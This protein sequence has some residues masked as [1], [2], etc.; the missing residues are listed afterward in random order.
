MSVFQANIDIKEPWW[1][2]FHLWR[3]LVATSGVS[4]SCAVASWY[5]LNF[6]LSSAS[7]EQTSIASIGTAITALLVFD[8]SWLASLQGASWQQ[9]LKTPFSARF[10]RFALAWGLI[11]LI[12]VSACTSVQSSV[13]SL[14][15]SYTDHPK[16]GW[17]LLG[18]AVVLSGYAL[19][20][21][22]LRL[23]LWPIHVFFTGQM[24]DLTPAWKATAAAGESLFQLTIGL[25]FAAF[26]L[27]IIGVATV[28]LPAAYLGLGTFGAIQTALLISC[29]VFRALQLSAFVECYRRKAVSI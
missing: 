5:L 29:I 23:I 10:W 14:Q 9:A 26:I 4:I 2:P 12:F 3:H 7:G 15:E 21:I 8:A 17:T 20:W 13:S 22:R 25:V 6:G 18:L 27:F 16:I 24:L 19:I 1:R 11:D 28:A